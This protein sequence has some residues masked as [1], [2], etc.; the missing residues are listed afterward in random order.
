[1]TKKKKDQILKVELLDGVL[2]GMLHM[3]SVQLTAPDLLWYRE[4]RILKDW[5]E[6]I[7]AGPGMA[8]APRICTSP[9]DHEDESIDENSDDIPYDTTNQRMVNTIMGLQDKFAAQYEMIDEFGLK[10][11]WGTQLNWANVAAAFTFNFEFSS[12]T[13]KGAHHFDEPQ[14]GKIQLAVYRD[15]TAAN[16]PPGIDLQGTAEGDW[17]MPSVHLPI[18]K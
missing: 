13:K 17:V 15:H 2:I 9:T 8:I 11:N 7:G 12:V 6:E 3:R 14:L 18:P 1:M 4:H 16:E 10:V 5:L